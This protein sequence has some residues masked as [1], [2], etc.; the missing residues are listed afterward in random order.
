MYDIHH[1]LTYPP[2]P[3]SLFLGRKYVKL[4]K[5]VRFLKIKKSELIKGFGGTLQLFTKFQLASYALDFLKLIYIKKYNLLKVTSHT[6]S[7]IHHN[8]I[9]CNEFSSDT[10]NSSVNTKLKYNTKMFKYIN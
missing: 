5:P 2:P 9:R 7:D 1:I 10:Q 4:I 3:V 6:L 8:H